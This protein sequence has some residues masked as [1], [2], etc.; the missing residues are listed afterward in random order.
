MGRQDL[1]DY[2][3]LSAARKHLGV[4]RSTF[5]RLVRR[6]LLAPLRRE[7]KPY[8]HR[9][10]VQAYKAS[11]RG[12]YA[13][14]EVRSLALQALSIARRN[15]QRLMEVFAR[16]GLEVIPLPRDESSVR[17]LYREAEELLVSEEL[18]ENAW[19]KYWS[20]C[21][22][23]MD[24]TYLEL[25]EFFV[26]N[27]EPWKV[28]FDATSKILGALRAENDRGLAL[29]IKRLDAARAHL[30]YVGYMYCRRVRGVKVANTVFDGRASAVDELSA[31]LF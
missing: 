11:A 6:G 27:D 3:T 9:V 17:A 2:L 30:R 20:G 12:R 18:K 28:F 7:G 14:P 4:S 5:A 21:L 1:E 8:F 13:L 19:V 24:E 10:E 29:V 25:V 16:L 22:F 23:S 26:A 31:I 15:E